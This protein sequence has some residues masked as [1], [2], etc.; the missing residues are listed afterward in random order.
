MTEQEP[1]AVSICCTT[2]NQVGYIEDA[3]KGFLSQETSFPFEILI[4]DDC[5]TDGTTDIVLKYAEEYPGKVIAVTHDENQYSKGH[6]MTTDFLYP[7]ARGKYIALCE[8]DDYWIDPLKLQRQYD[9]LENHPESSFCVHASKTVVADTGKVLTVNQPYAEDCEIPL[10]DIFE[11]NHSFATASQFMRKSAYDSYVS[12]GMYKVPGDGDFKM[13]AYYATL[14]P[15]IY[16][17]EP[18]SA[19]RVFAQN[20]IN[21]GILQL[22]AD[23][24]RAMQDRLRTERIGVLK[25]LDELTHGIYHAQIEEGVVAA[26]YGFLK[27]I[28]DVPAMKKQF[29]ERYKAETALRKLILF[30]KHSMPHTYAWIAKRVYHL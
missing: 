19:Y 9:A 4:N 21:R 16:L 23:E 2:Y 12:T 6:Y 24:Q 8:G 18:M 26:N 14:G 10:S 22:P 27:S 7:R 20:S 17:A 25:H 28:A 3:I 13:C 15:V 1:I 5:S 29:P 30:G 11:R